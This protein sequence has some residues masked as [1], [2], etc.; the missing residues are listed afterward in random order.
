MDFRGPCAQ[1]DMCYGANQNAV[2]TVKSEGKLNCD[3]EFRSNLY[4][5]CNEKYAT[6]SDSALD[7][8]RTADGYVFVVE[9][10]GGEER[11]PPSH[12]SLTKA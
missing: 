10:E 8:R 9:R 11:R 12:Q 2:P 1:H 7:C 3:E 5:N 4:A 6:D